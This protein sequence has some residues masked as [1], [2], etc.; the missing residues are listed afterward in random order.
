MSA[1]DLSAGNALIRLAIARPVTVIVGVVLVVFFGLLAIAGLPIQLTPDISTPSLTVTTQWPGASP[2]EIETE[3]LD[4]QEDVL[5]SVPGL[6]SLRSEAKA[7][8]GTVTLEL[9]VGTPLEEALVRVSNRLAQVPDYPA[10][11]REPVVATADAAG[12]PLAVITIR[13]PTGA[14]VAP[15]R[16]WVEQRVLPRLERVPGVASIRVRGGQDTVVYVDFDVAA[17]AARRLTV[18]GVAA[19]ISS[20]LRD[21]SAGDLSLGKRRYLVRTPVAPDAIADLEGLVLGAGPDGTPILLRDV[22]EVGPGLRKP[23]ALAFSDDRPSMVLLLWRESGTNVLEVSEEIR[24]TVERLQQEELGPEGLEI[25]LISDQTGYIEGALELVRQNL[26]V[27]GLLAVAV[28]LVFLRSVAAS[29]VVAVS[30]PVCVFGTALGMAVM[31]RSVNV[32]SLAGMAFAVGMVVDNSIVVL[33]SIDTWRSRVGTASQAALKGVGEVWGAILASTATTA[34]VFL[35]VIGWQDEVGEL[36]RDVAVAISFS[37]IASLFVAVLVVPS[38][39]ARVLPPRPPAAGPAATPTGLRAAIAGQVRALARSVPR[40]LGVVLG[41]LAGSAVV[42]S[43]L[44][45][46]MEYL[47]TGNRNLVFGILTPPPG[48]AL[49]ELR[50]IGERVQARAAAHRGHEID[51]QP[52]IE[53]SFFVGDPSQ[54]FMG[55]VGEDPDRV[56]ELVPLY[57]SLQAE[58]PGSFAYATQASLFA[59]RLGGARAVEV[60]IGG[61]DLDALLDT[62]GELMSAIEAALPGSQVRPIPSLDP[63]APEIHA[64]PRRDES[65]GLTVGGAELGLTVDALVDGAIVGEF[66]RE[67][68]PKVDVVLRATGRGRPAIADPEDLRNAPVATPRGAVVPLGTLA[69]VEERLGP[70]RIQRIERRRALTL[71]VA[72]PPELALETA[73]QRIRDEVVGPAHAAGEIPAGVDVV[74]SGTASKLEHAQTRFAGVLA[75]ALVISFLLLAALFE[76]FWAPIAVLTTIPLAAAGG[77]LGLRLVDIFLAPQPLDLMTALGFLILIG[78]VVNNAILVVDG[79]LVRLREGGVLE[80]AVAGAVAGRVRPILMTTL[81]SLAGLAPMVAFPG[82]G[83]ELYRGVGA[84]VLG[85]LCVSTALT[86]WV[87][88]CV[89]SLLW[90]LRARIGRRA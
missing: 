67:G 21:V 31:G 4:E 62:G 73:M 53:R 27:G 82:S 23:A 64:V 37:V 39:A 32:V 8:E 87:I 26:L 44:M 22:A 52:A 16:T 36:L 83:S 29:G 24:A 63:G 57:R 74:L 38:L 34:A 80:E 68:E 13:S 43:A 84:I 76:D 2:V 72:P 19:R 85:G 75:L 17:L 1:E 28:L 35:P 58:I 6:V 18:A 20:E 54:V 46:P 45:P 25:E 9:E 51:G 49:E 11:A 50:A 61:P 12:P 47:P 89:F 66:G 30:I 15:W 78:V 14:D 70:A 48:Y 77:F 69:R 60:E 33:E 81:T 40:S 88:P 3:I 79:A 7:D 65:A 59:S 41:T 56:A 86:L 10:A 42:A 55:A 90:R 5:K 71:Q